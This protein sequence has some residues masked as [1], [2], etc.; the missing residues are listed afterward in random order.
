MHRG[1]VS[2]WGLSK[3]YHK[4]WSLYVTLKCRTGTMS[5][6][7]YVIATQAYG[8]R[9]TMHYRQH[10]DAKDVVQRYTDYDFWL[11]RRSLKISCGVN[12]FLINC[13]P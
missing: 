5:V 2:S 8:V 3:Y 11:E 6:L 9:G 12:Y 4:R 13:F 1:A 10:R 7:R